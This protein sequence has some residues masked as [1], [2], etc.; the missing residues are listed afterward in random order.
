[1]HDKFWQR[2]LSLV[3]FHHLVTQKKIHC[4]L[5]K[6]VLGKINAPKLLDFKDFSFE[7]AISKLPSTPKAYRC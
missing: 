6:G 4:N 5:Y 3:N 7:I 2:V 1:M